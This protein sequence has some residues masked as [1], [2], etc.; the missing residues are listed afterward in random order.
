MSRGHVCGKQCGRF[1]EF[2]LAISQWH[3]TGRVFIL[4]VLQRKIQQDLDKC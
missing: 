4:A 2:E 3:L 1:L